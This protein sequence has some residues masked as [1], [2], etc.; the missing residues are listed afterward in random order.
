LVPPEEKTNGWDVRWFQG[1]LEVT[2]YTARIL[3]AFVLLLFAGFCVFGFLASF[4]HGD[5][6]IFRIGYPILFVGSLGASGWLLFKKPSR[7]ASRSEHGRD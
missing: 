3:I 7:A 1:L 5:F 4:E 6:M 2:M